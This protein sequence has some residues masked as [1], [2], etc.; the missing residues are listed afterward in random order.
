MSVSTPCPTSDRLGQLLSGNLAALDEAAVADH[1]CE[2]VVCQRRLEE[3]AAAGEINPEVL[4]QL[5]C[6]DRPP[7]D[8]AYWPALD[9]I[10]H[11]SAGSVTVAQLDDT[12]TESTSAVSFLQPSERPD[13]IGTFA[14][15]E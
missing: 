13:A 12:A 11:N 3:R 7:H 5:T 2:C 8:S 4:R 10:K 15:F 1:L 14:E 9:K 6:D